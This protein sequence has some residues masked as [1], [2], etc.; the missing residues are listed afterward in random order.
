[1]ISS[2]IASG[3]EHSSGPQVDRF[4]PLTMAIQI[5]HLMC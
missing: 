2:V 1:M 5:L 3:A 4:A